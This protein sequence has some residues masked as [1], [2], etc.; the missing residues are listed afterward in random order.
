MV[1]LQKPGT[2]KPATAKPGGAKKGAGKKGAAGDSKPAEALLSDEA[3][4]E[5]AIAFMGEETMNNLSNSNWKERLAAMESVE[6]VLYLNFSPG[7][8]VML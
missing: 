1:I 8:D 6:Q 7:N 2:A 4:E 3:V 5:K